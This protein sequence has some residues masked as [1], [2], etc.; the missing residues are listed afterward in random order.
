MKAAK[1]D[2]FGGYCYRGHCSADRD[3]KERRRRE[4]AE[5][6]DPPRPKRE[7]S[8]RKEAA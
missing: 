2:C 8:C 4:V 5:K 6:Q 7:K 1:C 3:E